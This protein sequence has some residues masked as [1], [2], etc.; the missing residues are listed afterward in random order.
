MIILQNEERLV[1]HRKES[2]L[3]KPKL[4]ISLYPN[5]HYNLSTTKALVANFST[6]FNSTPTTNSRNTHMSECCSSCHDRS[7]VDWHCILSVI[8]NDSMA[9]L[10]VSS[11]GFIFLINFY[12][13]T[14]RPLKEGNKLIRTADHHDMQIIHTQEHKV[15]VEQHASKI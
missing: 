11:D 6:T 5:M 12:T 9:R 8:R 2:Q 13:S 3:S 1:S 4:K 14:F 7:L 10:V 15:A